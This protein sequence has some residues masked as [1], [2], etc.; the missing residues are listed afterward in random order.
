MIAYFQKKGNAIYIQM[1]NTAASPLIGKI[2][3]YFRI[4]YVYMKP[5]R[6]VVVRTPIII[7]ITR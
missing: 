4:I 6:N 7:L 2:R 3:R 1:E 5:S